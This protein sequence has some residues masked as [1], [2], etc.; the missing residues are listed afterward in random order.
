[1]SQILI[2]ILRE[3]GVHY[4]LPLKG[5]VLNYL[6]ELK[7]N[8]EGFT[9]AGKAFTIYP[10]DDATATWIAQRL[11][12]AIKKAVADGVLVPDR[13]FE[14]VRSDARI[15]KTGA[16]FARYGKLS[17]GND[18]V[19]IMDDQGKFIPDPQTKNRY[20]SVYEDRKIPWPD[21]MN[22]KRFSNPFEKVGLSLDW[23]N[24]QD[25]KYYSWKDRPDTWGS[26]YGINQRWKAFL[27]D[28][29]QQIKERQEQAIRQFG[30]KPTLLPTESMIQPMPMM[31][32][33][34]PSAG[35][36]IMRTPKAAQP[37]LSMDGIYSRL[38]ESVMN[39]IFMENFKKIQELMDTNSPNSG[40]RKKIEAVLKDI[41]QNSIEIRGEAPEKRLERMREQF[42]RMELLRWAP[43]EVFKGTADNYKNSTDFLE[44]RI[45]GYERM[46]PDL[47][48]QNKLDKKFF[49]KS[50]DAVKDMVADAKN[51]PEAQKKQILQQAMIQ[52]QGMIADIASFREN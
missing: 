14:P 28:F 38:D 27:P 50:L 10:K 24:P 19:N 49:A 5:K 46:I 1:M 35:A 3:E 4:K 17:G 48:D 31:M 6:N 18:W 51:K 12:N 25:G 30:P 44:R 34:G 22:N 33:M 13:D 45:E 21:F 39:I 29:N 41:E 32:P 23:L 36:F 52:L 15:G 16:V 42:K 47:M 11:D 8:P 20:K 40:S 7:D 26:E 37:E 2:P 43:N 9:Q